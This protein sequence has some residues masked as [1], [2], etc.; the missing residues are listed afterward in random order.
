MGC[1]YFVLRHLELGL[2]EN[3]MVFWIQRIFVDVGGV[4]L[5]LF[6]EYYP[7]VFDVELGLTKE[8][9]EK[10]E[11]GSHSVTHCHKHHIS[12]YHLV[13]VGDRI[14]VQTWAGYVAGMKDVSL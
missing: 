4:Y 11:K 6:I 3:Y 13:V 8:I 10:K 14:H 1:L 2:Y 5:C 12:Q 7:Y 9:S